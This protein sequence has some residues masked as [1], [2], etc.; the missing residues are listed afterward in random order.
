[1]PLPPS[2][3]EAERK[4]CNVK[5]TALFAMTLGAAAGG[6]VELADSSALVRSLDAPPEALIIGCSLLSLAALLRHRSSS[7]VK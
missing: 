4:E 5:L 2:N 1:M 3:L 6:L 7:Q